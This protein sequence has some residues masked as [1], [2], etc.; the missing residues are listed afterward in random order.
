[1]ISDINVLVNIDITFPKD[2]T[3]EQKIFIVKWLSVQS[4]HNISYHLQL[5]PFSRATR[6]W[7]KQ[8]ELLSINI[9]IILTNNRGPGSYNVPVSNN[10]ITK[11][12]SIYISVLL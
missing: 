12:L 1:M 3:Q 4:I 9:F 11:G 5:I 10:R 6:L 2:V 7:Q 8:S